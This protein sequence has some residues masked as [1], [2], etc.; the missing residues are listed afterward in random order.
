MRLFLSPIKTRNDFGSLLNHMG[1]VGSGVEVG[2]HRGQFAE[3]LLK[4]WRGRL[5][6]VDN[7]ARHY[8]PIDPAANSDRSK[9]QKA[10]QKVVEEFQPRFDLI[11]KP[12]V[13]AAKDFKPESLDFAYI[14][15]S[16]QYKAVS[17][18]IK[19]WWPRVK[20][21]GVLAGH[22]ALAPGYSEDRDISAGVQ[23]A[24]FEFA[25]DKTVYLVPEAGCL[26]W[27]W[28]ILKERA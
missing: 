26:P 17:E 23:Q 12:S 3:I 24:L 11:K 28:Y 10:A 22:D 25:A 9:D 21:G 8:D 2:V 6:G 16:H 1:L 15:A 7:Y 18:D 19:A 20:P 13:E 5:F 27:S 14:D 4:Q